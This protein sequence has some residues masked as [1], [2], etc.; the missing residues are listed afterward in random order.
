MAFCTVVGIYNIVVH[1]HDHP[2]KDLPYS[3]MRNKPF[4]WTECPTC[5][6]LDGDCWKKCRGEEVEEHH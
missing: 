2:R 1:D 6:L 5:E 4:P 3:Q